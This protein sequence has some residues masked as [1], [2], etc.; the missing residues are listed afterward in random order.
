MIRPFT[1]NFSAPRHVSQTCR[2]RRRTREAYR[3]F[4]A[5]DDLA[6]DRLGRETCRCRKREEPPECS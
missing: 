1:T 5:V 6:A 2:E 3:A 4:Q